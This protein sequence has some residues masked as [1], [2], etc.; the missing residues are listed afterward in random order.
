[1]RKDFLSTLIGFLILPQLALSQQPGWWEDQ[2]IFNTAGIGGDHSPANIGQ[3]KNVAKK[4]L[5]TISAQNNTLATQIETVIGP[6]VLTPPT[7][8]PG[9]QAQKGVLLIGQLK[10]LAKPF[11]DKLAK[12]D[13]VWLAL[14][15]QRIG[16]KH[17][18]SIYPWTFV[19]GDDSDFSPASVGQLKA[20]FALDL[21]NLPSATSDADGDGMSYEWEV[22]YGLNPYDATD[23]YLDLNGDGISNLEHFNDLTDP[24]IDATDTDGDGTIDLIEAIFGDDPNDKYSSPKNHPLRYRWRN[25]NRTVVH[26]FIPGGTP[27]QREVHTSYNSHFEDNLKS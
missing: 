23:A 16:T 19:T 4:A 13:G 7:T 24:R 12:H 20:C 9:F 5:A 26:N 3:A 2:G 17:P 10:N 27:T 6:A 1:M 25:L 14:E 11:Y 8:T 15:R 21:G 22:R 18:R